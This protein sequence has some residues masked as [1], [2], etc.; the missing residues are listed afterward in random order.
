M[1]LHN[2][3]VLIYFCLLFWKTDYVCVG[4]PTYVL[5]SQQCLSNSFIFFSIFWI[6]FLMPLCLSLSV[7]L[8]MYLLYAAS[9]LVLISVVVSFSSSTSCLCSSNS[10]QLS[11]VVL[12]F[13]C[14]V[15]YLKDKVFFYWLLRIFS[16][17]FN[18]DLPRATVICFRVCSS[19]TICL[20]F[21]LS[22][23]SLIAYLLQIW[24]L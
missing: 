2:F 7:I 20:L 3:P 9:S 1:P 10:F 6:I 16:N 11:S 19:L 17:M 5:Q 4:S 21:L 12:T 14:E 22:F 13:L 18:Y 15:L 8:M 23:F 24:F